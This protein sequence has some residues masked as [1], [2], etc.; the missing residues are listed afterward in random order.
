MCSLQSMHEYVQ[1]LVLQVL[2][3]TQSKQANDG[4]GTAGGEED[5]NRVEE[6]AMTHAKSYD[7]CIPKGRKF[8]YICYYEGMEQLCS[9]L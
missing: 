1:C 5:T 3:T 6:I 4:Q 9:I 8:Y 2:P 7:I